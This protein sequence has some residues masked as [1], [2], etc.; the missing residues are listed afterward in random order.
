MVQRL[1]VAV[2]LLRQIVAFDV[3]LQCAPKGDIEYLKSLANGED[4]Q[5]ARER[6]PDGGKF[7]AVAFRV[8]LF[9]QQ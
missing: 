2:T 9:V 4:R 7:P 5:P 3:E 8:D 1:N 6:F